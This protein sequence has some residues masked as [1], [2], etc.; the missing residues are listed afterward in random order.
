MK[1]SKTPGSGRK[2][3]TPNKLTQA[4]GELLD[5]LAAQGLACDPIEFLARLVANDHSWFGR[6][7]SLPIALRM[8]AAIELAPYRAPKRKAVE[9]TG[10]TGPSPVMIIPDKGAAGTWEQR[11]QEL[12]EAQQRTLQEISK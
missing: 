3:G 4:V 7:G 10:N 2:K 11:A 9:V 8:K 6:K 12:R 5:S 1:G